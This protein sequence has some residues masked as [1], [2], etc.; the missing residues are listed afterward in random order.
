MRIV[1]LVLSQ[2]GTQVGSTHVLL[3]HNKNVDD[4]AQWFLRK[5]R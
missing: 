5:E 1:N 4:I 3:E 2:F